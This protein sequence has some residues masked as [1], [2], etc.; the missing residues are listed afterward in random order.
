MYEAT[1][2][3]YG[4]SSTRSRSGGVAEAR[5]IRCLRTYPTLDKTR[6]VIE[7]PASDGPQSLQ[8]D[9]PLAGAVRPARGGEGEALHVRA[10]RLQPRPRR[11]PAHVR[12]GR[13]DVPG[14]SRAGV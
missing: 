5:N 2:A 9:V 10:H 11:E 3:W 6:Q 7:N 8:H 12:V 4:S 14:L 13:P 1:S